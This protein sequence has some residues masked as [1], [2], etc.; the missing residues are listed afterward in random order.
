[1]R[2]GGVVMK[3]SRYREIERIGKMRNITNVEAGKIYFRRKLIR[4]SIIVLLLIICISILIYCFNFVINYE[5][6]RNK[7]VE[8]KIEDIVN[9][10]KVE[11]KTITIEDKHDLSIRNLLAPT[12]F[13]NSKYMNGY[14][15]KDKV[16]NAIFVTDRANKD[17]SIL[18]SMIIKRN[19]PYK[20]KVINTGAGYILYQYKDY[21]V[22]MNSNSFK[23]QI[24]LMHDL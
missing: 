3:R 14:F 15:H 20:V 24:R 12:G 22:N 9:S 4:F 1:M 21:K 17:E 6:N 10:S 13:V 5:T 7:S 16:S 2:F 18:D 8:N 19:K 23:T 11:A